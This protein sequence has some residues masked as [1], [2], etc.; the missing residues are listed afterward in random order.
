MTSAPIALNSSMRSL[1]AMIS[2]GHTKVLKMDNLELQIAQEKYNNK[3]ITNQEGRRRGQ[4]ICL[5]SLPE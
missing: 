5:C 2:V 4:H 3:S 1:K